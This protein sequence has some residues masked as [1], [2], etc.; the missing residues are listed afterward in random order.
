MEQIITGWKLKYVQM[1]SR[2]VL[3]VE[4]IEIFRLQ[5]K[6]K[7]FETLFGDE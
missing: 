4:G 6:T 2:A 5:D 3:H 1:S 7:K